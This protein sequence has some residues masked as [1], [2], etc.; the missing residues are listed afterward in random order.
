MKSTARFLG[1][2]DNVLGDLGPGF[3][4]RQIMPHPFYDLQP[5]SRHSFSC[6]P[7]SFHGDQ[8]VGITVDDQGRDLYPL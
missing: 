8:R 5:S 2:G 7:A 4:M 6:I 1:V 3:P